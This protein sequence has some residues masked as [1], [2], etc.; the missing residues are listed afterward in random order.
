M[1][2]FVIVVFG[3]GLMTRKLAL[4]GEFVKD[5]YAAGD[6]ILDKVKRDVVG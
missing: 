4:T 1:C 5:E 6:L 3:E 2:V